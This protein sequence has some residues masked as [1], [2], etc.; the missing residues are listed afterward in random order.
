MIIVLETLLIINFF[1]NIKNI[2]MTSPALGIHLYTKN[3][4]T[5]NKNLYTRQSVVPSGV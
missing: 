3:T 5:Q 2:F 1:F 4:Q